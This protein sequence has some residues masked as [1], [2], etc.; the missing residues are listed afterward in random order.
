M[1][2]RYV[3]KNH[4][5]HQPA[6]WYSSPLHVF[7]C[8]YFFWDRLFF[9]KFRLL[10]SFLWHSVLRTIIFSS[11][12]TVLERAFH[13]F[14]LHMDTFLNKFL[15]F[16]HSLFVCFTCFFAMRVNFGPCVLENWDM[17]LFTGIIPGP[18]SP[19]APEGQ[20]IYAMENVSVE[21]HFVIFD[22]RRERISRV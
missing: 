10:T 19:F 21:Q 3:C 13:L 6:S 5:A 7:I 4:C 12:P 8:I 14:L 17:P 2:F 11:S 18:M 15:I 1:F 22:S 16:L 20:E 9:C